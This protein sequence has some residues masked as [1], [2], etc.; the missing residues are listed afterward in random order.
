MVGEERRVVVRDINPD[1]A[2]GAADEFGGDEYRDYVFLDATHAA[3]AHRRDHVDVRLVPCERHIY[4]DVGRC[5]A[6]GFHRE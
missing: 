4:S 1:N 6:C 5:F 2:Y 3:S